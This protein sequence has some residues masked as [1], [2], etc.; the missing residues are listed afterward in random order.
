[1]TEITDNMQK[2][3]NYREQ[4]G[5]LSKAMKNG[6]FL[7][8]V[9]IE[10]AVMEDRLES[11]I[12]H[13]GRWTPKSDEHVSIHRKVKRVEKLA[14]EKNSP[15][16]KYFTAELLKSI[17]QWKE[18]RNDLMHKLMNQQL[19]TEDLRSAAES[20]QAIIKTLSSKAKSYHRALERIKPKE[21]TN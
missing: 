21:N 2:Y 17:L 13:S 4:M 20:G 12:R 5:R 3:A 15:A 16:Q 14:E 11:I 7:E 10:Y 9:S 1:M 18:D 8:A 6:F 19:H